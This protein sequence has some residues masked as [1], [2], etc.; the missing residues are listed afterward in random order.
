MNSLRQLAEALGW[1]AKARTDE[2]F[3]SDRMYWA[4]EYLWESHGIPGAE[5]TDEAR[6]ERAQKG[7]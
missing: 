5:A 2:I 1:I 7:K 4:R 3:E 6:R